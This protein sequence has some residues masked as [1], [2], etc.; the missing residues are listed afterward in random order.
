M[1]CSQPTKNVAITSPIA[2]YARQI[3]LEDKVFDTERHDTKWESD[4]YLPLRNMYPTVIF[5]RN[6]V[7]VIEY[8]NTRATFDLFLTKYVNKGRPV[9]IRGC[10]T[11]TS[12]VSIK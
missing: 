10:S 7:D 12:L 6:D 4:D 8:T 3:A 9:I 2:P 11:K 5:S 1:R